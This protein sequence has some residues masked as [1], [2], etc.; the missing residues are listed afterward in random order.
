M[1]PTDRRLFGEVMLDAYESIGQGQRYT[2]GGLDLMFAAMQDL[3]LQQIQQA[4]VQHI[5]DEKNGRWR[6]N[7]AM[8]RDQIARHA[9]AQWVSADEAWATA[10]KLESDAGVINQV[11]AG[12][13]AVAQSLIDSGD[14]I[15]AR[16]AFIDAYNARV[17]QAKA[18]PDPAQRVPVT[19]VSGGNLPRRDED[20]HGGRM[21]LL[22]RAQSAGLLRAPQVQRQLL[23]NAAPRAPSAPPPEFKAMLLK[24][25]GKT[26]P[27]PEEQDYE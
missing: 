7:T 25:Q 11:V 14:M 27:P 2:E 23:E 4:L 26:M 13:L 8:I 3:S 18:H 20:A 19:F 6:P 21:M 5:N 9:P 1:R 17:E 12:A 16:R 24:L 15:G 10:P 22:E